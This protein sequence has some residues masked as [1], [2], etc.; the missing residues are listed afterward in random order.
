MRSHLWHHHDISES[1]RSWKP[2]RSFDESA[3]PVRPGGHRLSLL[4]D[5]SV[6]KCL[7]EKKIV[8]IKIL[9]LKNLKEFHC[10]LLTEYGINKIIF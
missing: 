9:Y 10:F 2:T 3:N 6:I 5:F 8:D 4:P 7:K 1:F